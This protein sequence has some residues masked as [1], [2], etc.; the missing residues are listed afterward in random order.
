MGN[1]NIIKILTDRGELIPK[2]GIDLNIQFNRIVDDLQDVSNRFGDFTY[3]FD[4]PIIKENSIVFGYSNSHGM[5]KLFPKNRNISC[6]IYKNNSLLLNGVVNL[7]AVT[8]DTYR[9]KFYSKFKELIDDLT[10]VGEDGKEKSL[11]SLNLPTILN[12][13]YEGSIIEH[14]N[15][16]YK[17]SDETT[18]QYPLC[19]YSTMYCQKSYY[20]GSTE[21]RGGKFTADSPY[22]NFYY[23]LNSIGGNENRMYEHQYPPA[24]YLVS[25]V[26]QIM[27][28]AGWKLGGQFFNGD[29]VKKIVL[30]Y[31]GDEDIYD[32]ATGI[33][34][35]NTSLGLQ[36]SKFLPDMSQ[37]EFLKG[38]INYFNLYFKIDINNKIIELEPYD[39]FFNNADNIDSYDITQKINLDTVEFSYIQNNNPTIK[40]KPANN[41]K[42]FGDNRVMSGATNNA[43]TQRWLSGSSK[44]YNQVFNRVGTTEKIEVPFAEPNVKKHIMYNNYN[45]GGVNKSAGEHFIYLPLLSKQSPTDNDGMKFNKND[46]ETYVFNDES[47]IKFAGDCT[48]M[49]YYG[50]STCDFENKTGKGG[51]SNYMYTNI[52]SGSTLYRQRI[53]VCSPWQL[54]NYNQDQ[55]NK[56]LDGVRTMN[57]PNIDDRSTITASYLKSLW[58]IIGYS[59][60]V[61]PALETE[62]SLVFDDQPYLHKTLWSVFHKNKWNRYANSE[63]LTATMRMTE[64]DWEEMQINRPIQYNK[65]IYNIVSIEGYDP[66]QN[67]ANITLIKKL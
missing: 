38:V 54:S 27:I 47:S 43:Y 15:A 49:Y 64:Y 22:Q 26:K 29:N 17:N 5:K 2:E 8:R 51:I 20:S 59:T 4:L 62:Y 3:D 50:L 45:Y 33:Y 13:K 61:L 63:L 39:V 18:H 14:I 48:L 55:I 66:I 42:T 58:Q 44:A 36:L 35:G 11:R 6:Q 65:E 23:C 57:N 53:G 28:D 12:W 40:F 30:T 7:E 25:I 1:I 32:Q 37:A 46:D 9:C 67:S 19:Y 10:E 31:A 56:Y 52:Y 21:N 60:G 41:Q 16:D 24:I 34:S